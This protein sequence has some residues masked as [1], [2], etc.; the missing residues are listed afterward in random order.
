MLRKLIR[1]ALATARDTA[2]DTERAPA[3]NAQTVSAA[4]DPRFSVAPPKGSMKLDSPALQKA[5][6]VVKAIEK[7]GG[8]AEVNDVYQFIKNYEV[9][10]LVTKSTQ[11]FVDEY[12]D[13]KDMGQTIRPGAK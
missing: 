8:K 10:E 11:E 5:K 2:L 3:G 6:S 12:E 9:D 13:S 4:A 1:E 7:N